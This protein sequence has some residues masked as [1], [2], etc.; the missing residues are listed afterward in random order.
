ML[1]SIITPCLNEAAHI[2][3]FTADVFRQRTPA[4]VR[5]ELVIA[6]GRSNDGTREILADLAQREDRL[7]IVDNPRRTT[8]AGLNLAIRNAAGD[9]L[10]RMD[11]HTAYAEDYVA[12]C[13]EA[14]ES[15]GADNVGGPWKPRGAG[16]VSQAVSL[17]FASPWV[18][19]GG[20]AHDPR[21]QGWVDTV[22]LGCW[23]REV[24]ERFG[25]FDESLNRAQDSEHNFRI[26]RGGGRIHQTPRI[27][28]WYEP[29]DSLGRL[30][31]QYVQYGYWKV[32]TLRK[33]GRPAS[34]RQ[35]APAALLTAL[36]ATLLLALFWSWSGAAFAALAG[37]YAAGSAVTAFDLCRRSRQ[38]RLL[39][40]LPAVF[41]CFHFGFGYGYLRGLLRFYVLGKRNGTAEF[42]ALT[43]AG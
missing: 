9:V 14:L 19:G 3:R 2:R 39:P 35:L 6:D 16:T 18:A 23:R 37:A 43:R 42:A 26:I 8:P 36:A 22:Y 33:H 30:F 15:S 40:I 1:V 4:G 28:S 32:A 21:Y 38:W 20:R 31:R 10:V 29:R 24:F 34:V 25:L 7:R 5:I 11:V 12:S 13:L 17:S 27:R 41:A